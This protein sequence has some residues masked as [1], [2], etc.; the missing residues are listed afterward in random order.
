MAPS[1]SKSRERCE[2]HDDQQSES[3]RSRLCERLDVKAVGIAHATD[4]R[5][6]VG[7]K[8]TLVRT[9][10]CSEHG[11]PSR[12]VPRHAP[13]VR[14]AVSGEAEEPPVQIACYMGWRCLEGRVALF[15]ECYGIAIP[16]EHGRGGHR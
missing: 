3:K 7:K 2:E 15:D 9:G 5:R 6:L 14:S 10:S 4:V 8:V 11:M 12:V 1:P 16:T 13:Q